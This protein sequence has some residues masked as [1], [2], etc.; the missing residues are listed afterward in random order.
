MPIAGMD[1]VFRADNLR[2]GDGTGGKFGRA[3]AFFSRL[4]LPQFVFSLL[5]ENFDFSKKASTSY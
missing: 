3:C 4:L 1:V 2:G 5:S